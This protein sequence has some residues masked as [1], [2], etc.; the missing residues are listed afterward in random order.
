MSEQPL[1]PGVG[2]APLPPGA[3]LTPPAFGFRDLFRDRA[4]TL[5][6]TAVL[7]LQMGQ[8]F[9]AAF[10]GLMLTAIYRENGLPLDMFW[11]FTIP[12][13]PTWLRPL[14]APLVDGVGSARLGLRKSW[15]IPCTL[16]GALAY[17]SLSLFAPTLDDLWII[18]T[19]L[20]IKTTIMTTQD[21]A[22]DGYMVENLEDHERGVGAALMDIGRNI[23]MFS[24]W[25][26]V[27]WVYSAHGWD[28]AVAT[29]AGLLVLFSVPGIVRAEPPP[30][31]HAQAAR[32]RGERPSLRRL[33]RRP[34]A[35]LA[36]PLIMLT[37]FGSGLITQLYIPFLV[38]KG[39]S[40]GQIGISIL[41]PATLLG[42]ILGASI[43]V[44]FLNR[45]GYRPTLLAAAI[46]M[47][48]T[49]VPIMWLGNLQDPTLPIVFLVT[50]NGIF[51][52][53]FV[54][55]AMAGARLK[56]ASKAQA[57]TDYTS[58]IVAMSAA[59]GLSL[60]V[61]GVLAEHLGWFLYF[62]CAGVFV[63]GACGA[64]YLLF[65]RVE[66][67]VEARDREELA[68]RDDPRPLP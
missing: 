31:P 63:V 14:W 13:V 40:V 26:G 48:P 4:T 16:F 35:R 64:V 27:V 20:T 65:D 52:P 6:F 56:W 33:L 23:A 41:A 17:L 57:A 9:P 18:I 3:S 39:F 29:A 38:D 49:V 21:I 46:L 42:T 54:Q 5:K 2:T 10:F 8:V 43:T 32:A 51:L 45:F 67:L 25:A 15:F 58:Q 44:T 34:D 60:A 22:I 12:A 19:I 1:T 7:G 55:V 11:V 30:P 66:A 47:V 62:L 37:A 28:A 36:L 50:L 61:G 24:S 53:S 68:S 59:S